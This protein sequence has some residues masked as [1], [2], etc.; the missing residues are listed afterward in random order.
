MLARQSWSCCPWSVEGGRNGTCPACNC[1]QGQMNPLKCCVDLGIFEP[2][3][4]VVTVV[5]R[6][7][8]RAVQW[9]CSLK[10]VN[11]NDTNPESKVN[12]MCRSDMST[13]FFFIQIPLRIKPLFN[14]EIK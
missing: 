12:K 4:C 10:E 3:C 1:F 5:T 7:S 2:C 6:I 11:R 8:I 13:L 9:F 14:K